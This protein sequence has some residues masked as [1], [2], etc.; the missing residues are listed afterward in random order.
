MAGA[1]RYRL[2][3]SGFSLLE[4]VVAVAILGISLG[5]L[6]Q[7]AGGATRSISTSED[8]AYAVVMA[9]SLLAAHSEVP[10]EGVSTSGATGDGYEW[11]VS[12]RP[13]MPDNAIDDESTAS[14]HW[15]EVNVSWGSFVSPREFTLH[16]AVPVVEVVEDD[17]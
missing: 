6:Y 3:Q 9:Q 13:Y 15:I 17:T 4:M 11:E 7:A 16:S 5:M 1:L 14:L 12:S 10:P 8:Y 2:P